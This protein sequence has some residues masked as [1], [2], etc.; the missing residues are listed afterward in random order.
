MASISQV[1][2]KT[3]KSVTYCL[4]Y[5]GGDYRLG[6]TAGASKTTAV[7]RGKELRNKLLTGI[8]GFKELNDAIQARAKHGVIKAID[9]RPIR[10]LGKS[11]AALNYLLQSC[12]AV[13]CKLWCIRTNELLKE[14]KI[15][16]WPMAFVHDEMQLS[17]KPEHAQKACELAKIAMKDVQARLAFRCELDCDTQI[18]NS[19]ADTH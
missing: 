15:D 12:G 7:K 4:I 14:N 3:Q 6:I 10:L 2:R 19:W 16:Y 9:G 1:D 8:K 17:V 13:I 11:H 18:G 5:G